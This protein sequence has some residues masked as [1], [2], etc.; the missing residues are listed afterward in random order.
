MKPKLDHR[1]EMVPTSDIERS[2]AHEQK[3]P[4]GLRAH[5]LANLGKIDSSE[6]RWMTYENN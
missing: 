6:R 2:R 4:G 1:M 5:S 3:S